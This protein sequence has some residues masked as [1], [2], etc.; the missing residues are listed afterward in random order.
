MGQVL[1]G[2]KGFGSPGDTGPKPESVILRDCKD[3]DHW[4]KVAA[5]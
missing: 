4:P 3:G 1:G 2:M 5:I